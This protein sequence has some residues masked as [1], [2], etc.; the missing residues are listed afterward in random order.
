RQTQ[1]HRSRSG[2]QPPGAKGPPGKQV[3]TVRERRRV[4]QKIQAAYGISERRAIRITGFPRSSMRY[5]SLR[6]PQD[7]LRTRIRELAAQRPRWGYRR[8]HVLLRR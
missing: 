6:A 1:A 2:L 4:V 3:V 7:E 8:I 5:R